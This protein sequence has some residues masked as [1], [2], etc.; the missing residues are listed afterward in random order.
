M[1]N[2][3]CQFF[4]GTAVDELITEEQ[5]IEVLN[6]WDLD[7]LSCEQIGVDGCCTPMPDPVPPAKLTELNG[8]IDGPEPSGD[9]EEVLSCMVGE[10][11][12]SFAPQ[13]AI[14]GRED[15]G[16]GVELTACRIDAHDGDVKWRVIFPLFSN[17]R[18]DAACL[19]CK[20]AVV[21]LE[22][23]VTIG[24]GGI[25]PLDHVCNKRECLPITAFGE[26]LPSVLDGFK[27]Y[28]G[29]LRFGFWGKASLKA[30][31][32]TALLSKQLAKLSYVLP[33]TG[34]SKFGGG[35]LLELLEAVLLWLV[36]EEGGNHA[37]DVEKIEK[38]CFSN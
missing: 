12:D 15:I 11:I 1:G 4:D 29:L 7:R 26:G 17:D 37:L 36:D 38:S 18:A 35:D 24:V 5:V 10:V 31:D 14:E 19:A 23:I 32:G 30:V 3:R 27:P 25:P 6:R 22:S 20:Q 2:Q 13:G 34:V 28:H 21:S 16:R 9:G 8:F 33:L